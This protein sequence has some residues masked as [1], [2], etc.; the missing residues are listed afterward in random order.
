MEFVKEHTHGTPAFPVAS[1]A[2]EYNAGP[3]FFF[4][5]H[6]HDEL[7]FFFVYSGDAVVWVNTIPY[8]MQAGDFLIMPSSAIHSCSPHSA[9]TCGTYALLCSPDFLYG[10]NSDVIFSEYLKRLT[11]TNSPALYVS[12]DTPS[13]SRASRLFHECTSMFAS[14]PP[15]YELLVKSHLLELLYLAFTAADRQAPQMVDPAMSMIKQSL[16]YIQTHLNEVITLTDLAEQCSLSPSQYGRL[17]KRVMACTPVT[18]LLEKRISYA[19]QLLTHTDIKVSDVALKTGFNN[20]SYF[21]RC[22]RR[23]LGI[24]PSE[25]RQKIQ[26]HQ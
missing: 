23:Y 1:Y 6:Y 12:A 5:P 11:D 8:T 2:I 25:Y 26:Q 20:F 17:F 16:D 14:H 3:E 15:A 21:N 9:S 4:F 13:A 22:F 10:R 7:E 24:T 18:Y 19:R